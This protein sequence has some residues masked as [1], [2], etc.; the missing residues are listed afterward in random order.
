MTKCSNAEGRVQTPFYCSSQIGETE[1]HGVPSP[2]VTVNQLTSNQENHSALLEIHIQG[3]KGTAMLVQHYVSHNKSYVYT[4]L[5][6]CYVY[7]R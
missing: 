1:W 2:V 4:K 5:R 7:S 6:I 3:E